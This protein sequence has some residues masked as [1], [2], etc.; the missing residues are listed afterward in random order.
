MILPTFGGSPQVWNSSM[1]FFQGVLLLG[2]LYAHLSSKHLKTGQQRIGQVVLLVVALLTL[3]MSTHTE[4]F[5]RVQNDVPGATNASG[6]VFLTL[7]ALVGLPFF[8]MSANSS[9]IQRWFSTTKDPQ[10]H[11]PYFLYAAGNFGSMIAL[12][13]YPTLVEPMFGLTQQTRLWSTG[14]GVMVVLIGLVALV[15]S[16]NQPSPALEEAAPAEKTVIDNRTRVLWMV[17]SAVPSSLLLGVTTYLT[18][19]IAPVPLLWVIPLALYLLTFILVFARKPLV[20]ADLLGRLLPL[21]VLPL[22]LTIVLESTSPIFPL[23]ALHLA[24]FFVATWMCHSR[25][26]LA[27]PSAEHLTEFFLWVSIGGVIGGIFNALLAPVVFSTLAEYPIALVAACLLRPGINGLRPLKNLARSQKLDYLYPATVGLVA[28]G[29]AGTV[30]YGPS[31]L[32]HH[33]VPG[34]PPS[35]ARTFLVIGI[36]TILS[37]LAVDRPRRFALSLGAIFLVLNSLHVASEG[38]VALTH[39]SFFGVHRVT[40]SPDGNLHNLTHGNTIHGTQNILHPRTPLT[41][42]YPNGPIGQ[43]MMKR[44]SQN[45]AFVGLG[46]GS[47]AAYGQTGQH[48]TYFEIDPV[49]LNIARDSGYFSF[50]KD[51]HAKVDVVLGDARLT[52]AKQNDKYGLI[53]LDAFSSDA[54]PV[55]LLTEEAIKMYLSKLEPGGLLAFH[56]SNRYVDLVPV[57]YAEAHDLG[58]YMESQQDGATAEEAAEGKKQSD[59]VLMGKDLGAFGTLLNDHNWDSPM[60]VDKVRPW[61][62]DYSNVLGSLKREDD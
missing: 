30:L 17:L 4:W 54:I 8:A 52:L 2:Y 23:G 15:G 29:I 22:A 1:L 32:A 6:L 3:P 37:F 16:R 39:R 58:L 56:I 21:L 13:A 41:Y 47:L 27:R 38:R 5:R 25:L 45:C 44:P 18:S 7:L 62:D 49:V 28:I 48:Y 55:H 26:S 60:D 36:P 46:V 11:S 33:A 51:S 24:V 43:V 19:S 9:M 31:I 42:Y 40:I 53:V 35:T 61:T 34:M 12:I 50:L 57:L 20:P 14:F 10:A 59:Y